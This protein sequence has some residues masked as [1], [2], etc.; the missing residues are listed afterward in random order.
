MTHREE[1]TIVLRQSGGNFCGSD[2]GH[3]AVALVPDLCL[4]EINSHQPSGNRLRQLGQSPC[5]FSIFRS[6]LV[7]SVAPKD[8]A[9]DRKPRHG[10]G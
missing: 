10:P 6:P 9:G 2:V 8:I 3:H 4:S 5:A 1:I 7:G